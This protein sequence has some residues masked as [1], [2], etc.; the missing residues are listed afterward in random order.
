MI[1]GVIAFAAG[2]ISVLGGVDSNGTPS[3]NCGAPAVVVALGGGRHPEGRGGD[4]RGAGGDQA[5][6][7]AIFLLAG[8]VLVFGPR[9]RRWRSDWTARD[10]RPETENG[11]RRGSPP[12]PERALL[13]SVDEDS[14]PGWG[15]ALRGAFLGLL[16]GLSLRRFKKQ[17]SAGHGVIALRGVYLSFVMAIGMIGLVVAVL[18]TT[19]DDF[20]STAVLPVAAIVVALG[21]ATLAAPM[22][23]T[24]PLRCESESALAEGYRQRFFLRLAFAEAAALVGFIGFIVSSAGW[25][26]PVGALF[27]AIGF[28]EAQ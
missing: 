25:L 2:L 26:Y 20:G 6:G 28:V 27:S 13:G 19:A 17:L 11:C 14:D 8:V 18:E 24:R 12:D 15:S 9:I 23:L 3:V 1:V 22:L 16:P 5:L 7:G 4:C 21:L 10:L